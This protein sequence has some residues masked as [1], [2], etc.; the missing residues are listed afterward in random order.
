MK[1]ILA[2]TKVNYNACTYADGKPVALRIVVAVGEAPISAPTAL[3]LPPLLFS[4]YI[5]Q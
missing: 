1:S 5:W 4:Q 3:D 2:L